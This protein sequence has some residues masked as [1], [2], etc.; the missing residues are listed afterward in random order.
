MKLINASWEERNSG[1]K[2]CEIV[3]E[4]GDSI[5]DY[6]SAKV[7]ESYRYSVVKVPSDNINLVHNLEEVG[8]RY[9]E[10]QFKVS[11]ATSELEKIDKKWM[12]IIK[13]TG[14]MKVTSENDL[15]EILL[16]IS[17]GMFDKDRISL[18][19]KLGMVISSLRYANWIKDLYVNKN[20]KIFYLI[21][22]GNKIGFFVIQQDSMSTI[23]SVIAGIFKPFQGHGLSVALIYYYLKL[24]SIMGA[25]QS[26]TSF[27]SNNLPMLNTF[28][29]TVSFKVLNVY[30]V[31]RR[32]IEH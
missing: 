19:N 12:K 26:I 22:N 20:A 21:K 2:T 6:L 25:K 9:V 29:K 8:Y 18:D 31:L 11:V 32:I 10:S 4:K 14:Y 1:L 27:S 30:Y 16:N 17:S 28:S 7:E 23:H 5:D 24:A 15:D 3:F 13:D